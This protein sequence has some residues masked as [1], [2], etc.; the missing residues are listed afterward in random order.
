[1]I[2]IQV[3]RLKYIELINK[4]LQKQAQHTPCTQI[5]AVPPHVNPRGFVLTSNASIASAV[6]DLAIAEVE[7][8][9][10]HDVT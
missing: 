9:Y 3:S 8:K 5:K 2:R 6:L 7:K 4:E 10:W 1:M